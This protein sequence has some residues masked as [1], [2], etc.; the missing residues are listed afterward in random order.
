LQDPNG[1]AQA[2]HGSLG[3]PHYGENLPPRSSRL[4]RGYSEALHGARGRCLTVG[5]QVTGAKLENERPARDGGF[6][7]L[8][9][10]EETGPPRPPG[11]VFVSSVEYHLV[12]A[13]YRPRRCDDCVDAR[14]GE[15]PVAADVDPVVSGERAENVGVVR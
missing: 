11:S 10:G 12:A 6:E 4:R 2:G 3:S 7:S 15:E 9:F 1:G 14:A 5:Q 8:R 13:P